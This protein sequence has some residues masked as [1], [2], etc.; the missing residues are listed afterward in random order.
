MRYLTRT[1]PS[2]AAAAYQVIELADQLETSRA[3]WTRHPACH[4]CAAP[5][6]PVAAAAGPVAL[7]S[8]GPRR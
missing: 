4:L 2:V 8:A 3:P 1:D 6:V 7:A 5:G